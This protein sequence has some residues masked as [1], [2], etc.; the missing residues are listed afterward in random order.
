MAK[1][2]IPR[3]GVETTS[4]HADYMP[5]GGICNVVL[6]QIR[7]IIRASLSGDLQIHAPGRVTYSD[8]SFDAKFMSGLLHHA[9]IHVVRGLALNQGPPDSALVRS[10]VHKD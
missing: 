4:C 10:S 5:V 2:R 9:Q 7:V 6:N 1:H 8:A 3:P